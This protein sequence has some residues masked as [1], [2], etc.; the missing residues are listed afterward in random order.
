M[1]LTTHPSFHLVKAVKSLEESRFFYQQI[2]GASE[3]VPTIHGS[4]LISSAT[5]WLPLG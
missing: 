3:G 2:L 5:N 4:T 1:V